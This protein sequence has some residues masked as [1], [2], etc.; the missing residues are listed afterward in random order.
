MSWLFAIRWPNVSLAGL[1][2]RRVSFPEEPQSSPPNTESS[3]RF[4]PGRRVDCVPK[5]LLRKLLRT[6]QTRGVV[7][8]FSVVLLFFW[9][10]GIL[11][12]FFLEAAVKIVNALCGHA[13]R[14]CM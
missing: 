13:T 1:R 9:G 11:Q 6:L 5:E 4:P 8:L 10:G 7:K 14:Y 2:R 3:W 12:Y